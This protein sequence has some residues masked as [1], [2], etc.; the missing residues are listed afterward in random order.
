MGQNIMINQP[1]HGGALYLPSLSKRLL[2]F[3]S[4][5]L[6]FLVLAA[7]AGF[8]L[9]IVFNYTHISLYHPLIQQAVSTAGTDIMLPS[10]ELLLR[11]T[12]YV[13]YLVFLFILILVILALIAGSSSIGRHSLMNFPD[14]TGDF[15]WSPLKTEPCL[16]IMNCS[17]LNSKREIRTLLKKY[18]MDF[19]M[20][21]IISPVA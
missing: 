13:F 19:I 15:Q 14:L 3:F 7:A 12:L 4:Q 20:V 2:F 6:R 10:D 5:N 11:I 16:L 1:D 21:F 18:M 9:V 8:I 17:L